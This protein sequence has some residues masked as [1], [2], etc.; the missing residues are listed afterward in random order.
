MS[1]KG[2]GGIQ[3]PSRQMSEVCRPNVSVNLLSISA[4]KTYD[5]FAH[6]TRCW[7]VSK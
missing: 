7:R 1:M 2:K 4:S 6:D 3:V 5:E